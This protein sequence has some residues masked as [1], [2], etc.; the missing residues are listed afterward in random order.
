MLPEYVN[1]RNALI[2]DDRMHLPSGE[3]IPNDG[4]GQ[5]LKYAIDSW[6]SANRVRQDPLQHS[7]DTAPSPRNIHS[8]VHSRSEKFSSCVNVTHL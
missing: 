2:I 6:L 4:S 1:A 8:I 7:L 5:G 3:R